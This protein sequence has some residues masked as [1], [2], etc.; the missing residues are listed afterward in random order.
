[1]PDALVF[2][3]NNNTKENNTQITLDEFFQLYKERC[4][5]FSTRTNTPQTKDIFINTGCFSSNFIRGFY[6]M[7]DQEKI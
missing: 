6:E 2:S 5:N 7:C 1:M 3:D 4:K